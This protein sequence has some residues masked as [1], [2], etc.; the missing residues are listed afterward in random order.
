[1]F[2]VDELF[3]KIHIS[4]QAPFSKGSLDF[5]L[6]VTVTPSQL[7]IVIKKRIECITGN[8]F[9]CVCDLQSMCPFRIHVGVISISK[10]FLVH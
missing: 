1:M 6:I 4:F 8:S 5:S 9:V 3:R 10:G 7:L 2:I